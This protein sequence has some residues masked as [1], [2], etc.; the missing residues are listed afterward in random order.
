MVVEA[1]QGGEGRAAVEGTHVT[2]LILITLTH[3]FKA[4]VNTGCLTTV[5]DT[6]HLENLALYKHELDT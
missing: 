6:G 2:L 4:G 1:G 3:T 5:S